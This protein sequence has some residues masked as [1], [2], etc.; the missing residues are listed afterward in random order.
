M[1]MFFLIIVCETKPHCVTY[2]DILSSPH[3]AVCLASLEKLFE[4][5]MIAE[6]FREW[7]IVQ[8]SLDIQLHTTIVN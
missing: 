3:T 1:A 5:Y 7:S 2:N 4:S 6:S 8:Y